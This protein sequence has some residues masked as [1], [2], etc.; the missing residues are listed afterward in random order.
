METDLEVIQSDLREAACRPGAYVCE[1]GF[2]Q[3]AYRLE[4]RRSSRNGTCV[5]IALLTVSLPDGSM[6]ALKQLNMTMDQFLVALQTQLRSGDVVSRYS[7]V[8]YVVMLPA[9][10]FEDSQKVMERIVSAFYR[11]HRHNFL[12]ITYK[13]REVE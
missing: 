9:A 13:I 5:H 1:Y 3:E 4:A 2:F 7:A 12:K 11:Q 6:P 10:N 8:Q